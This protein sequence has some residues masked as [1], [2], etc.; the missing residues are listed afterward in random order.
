M[1]WPCLR[2]ALAGGLVALALAGW[3]A[4]AA[5]PSIYLIELYRT[6]QVLIH[7]Y[8][9]PNLTYELQYSNTRTANGTPGGWTTLY[10][11]PNLPFPNHY[12]IVD[13]RTDPFRFYRLKVSP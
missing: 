12:I 10:V 8:T 2:G 5:A 9:D 7:F 3:S 11:A 6:N 1:F 4:K 13:T